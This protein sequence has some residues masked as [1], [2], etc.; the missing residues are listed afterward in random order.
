[1]PSARSLSPECVQ[2]WT[3]REERKT[4]QKKGGE[5][6][7]FASPACLPHPAF[8]LPPPTFIPFFF[9]YVYLFLSLSHTETHTLLLLCSSSLSAGVSMRTES[10]G[11]GEGK[12]GGGWR[13][14]GVG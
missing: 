9:L 11:Y 1:M 7:Q 4:K 3:Q 10:A 6:K 2:M 13:I 14:G 5:K 12:G 8:L